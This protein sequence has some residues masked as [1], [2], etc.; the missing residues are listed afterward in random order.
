MRIHRML[1]LG[2]VLSVLALGLGTSAAA[3]SASPNGHG[4]YRD[5]P[6]R[7]KEALLYKSDTAETIRKT[8]V[9]ACVS[10]LDPTVQSVTLTVDA[11]KEGENP[12]SGAT[13]L[14]TEKPESSKAATETRADTDPGPQTFEKVSVSDLKKGG[15]VRACEVDE[16]S[17]GRRAVAYT[18]SVVLKWFAGTRQDPNCFDTDLKIPDPTS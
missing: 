12:P 8:R 2:G 3:Q 15:S 17:D 14:I 5:D 16:G 4:V 13:C 10:D 9:A 7:E 11:L 1:I 18:L 6:A